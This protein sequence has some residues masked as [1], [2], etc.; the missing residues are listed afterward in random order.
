[1]NAKNYQ[2]YY[3]NL[4]LSGTLPVLHINVIDEDGNYDNDIIAYDLSHKEYFSGNY[5]LDLNGCNYLGNA[6]S[7]GS[8]SEPLPLEIKAR[9][10][11]TMRGFSKKPF[12]LKL[13]KKQEL[14]GL[15]N[16]KHF[17]LLANADDNFG[18]LRNYTAFNLGKRI[19]LPWTP[20]SQPVEV[21]ING[22]YRG[23]YFLTESI[24]VE[25]GR[26]N[27]CELE[28]EETDTSL[29]SGGY[30][31]ELDNY[32]KDENSQIR[33]PEKGIHHSKTNVLRVTFDTP[34]VYSD[35]QY[36]FIYD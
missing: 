29:I 5:W 21:I 36:R 22:D 27:L 24:R 28:D 10:N 14:L 25:N 30:V 35:I 1:M 32:N 16:S 33:I 7:I 13:G 17:A 8:E 19:G 18:F 20:S 6:K 3:I 34:E 12:K 23:L 4:G 26:L 2:E 31:V 11:W 9:G 15:S